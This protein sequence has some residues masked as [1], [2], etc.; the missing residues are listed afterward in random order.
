MIQHHVETFFHTELS[1]NETEFVVLLR[2]KRSQKQLERNRII[3]KE[4]RII[5][6]STVTRVM[7]ETQHCN[8]V[9]VIT[10]DEL[11]WTPIIP[12]R[13][14]VHKWM[15]SQTTFEKVSFHVRART[16]F[17]FGS[18]GEL[19]ASKKCYV[20]SLISR[21]CLWRGNAIIPRFISLQMDVTLSN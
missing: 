13:T 1:R 21:S 2:S 9:V 10:K 15:K 6:L 4:N 3:P 11:M 18:R 19:W 7:S 12:S 17:L 14:L 20:T 8:G 16:K 5:P